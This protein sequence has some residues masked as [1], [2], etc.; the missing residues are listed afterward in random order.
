MR[1]VWLGKA[2]NMMRKVTWNAV[3][4]ITDRL[5]DIAATRQS[6]FTPRVHPTAPA[7]I[8]AFSSAKTLKAFAACHQLDFLFL[9][10][11]GRQRSA[12]LPFWC[13]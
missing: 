11:P 6:T 7:W 3:G 4:T 12:A 5:P 9:P 2:L 8:A 10:S 1:V 13:R